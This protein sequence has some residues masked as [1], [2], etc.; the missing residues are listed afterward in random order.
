MAMKQ[1]LKFGLNTAVCPSSSSS[2]SAPLLPSPPQQ[3]PAPVPVLPPAGGAV[4]PIASS[5]PFHSSR[6]CRHG[7]R[8]R[9]GRDRRR[10]RR[11]RRRRGEVGIRGASPPRTGAIIR[12]PRRRNRLRP[13]GENRLRLRLLR[14]GGGGGGRRGAV[15]QRPPPFEGGGRRIGFGPDPIQG[16]PSA[17]GGLEGVA[18]AAAAPPPPPL[19]P[20]RLGQGRAV[21][22]RHGVREAGVPSHVGPGRRP[23]TDRSRSRRGS[24]RGCGGG[25]GCGGAAVQLPQQTPLLGA[26]VVHGHRGTAGGGIRDRCGGGR[27]GEFLSWLMFPPSSIYL[28]LLLLA[29]S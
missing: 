16:D 23:G 3:G 28:L 26:V 19:L 6:G 9:Q 21:R 7:H 12:A 27:R 29:R 10:R 8:Y 24:R 14:R 18:R 15:R 25:C 22:S 11:R 17:R 20:E 4:W 5:S 13:V 1:A 2:S